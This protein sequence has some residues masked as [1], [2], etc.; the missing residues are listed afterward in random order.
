M[1]DTLV[2]IGTFAILVLLAVLAL[3]GRVISRNR[4]L[5][6]DG[7]GDEFHRKGRDE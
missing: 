2:Y 7:A 3:W 6:G 4:G 1:T 5:H